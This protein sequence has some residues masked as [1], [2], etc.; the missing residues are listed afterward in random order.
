MADPLIVLALD[1]AD[2]QLA[3]EFA[4]V[5]EWYVG[6]LDDHIYPT[7][8]GLRRSGRPLRRGSGRLYPE[9]G[10]VCGTCL[11]WWRARKAKTGSLPPETPA[12]EETTDVDR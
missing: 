2:A 6:H 5:D 1:A 9:A 8:P 10:D 7:C 12:T 4:V 11:R 3:A